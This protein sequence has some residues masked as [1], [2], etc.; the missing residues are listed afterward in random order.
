MLTLPRFSYVKPQ[1]IKEAISYYIRAKKAVYLAGGTDLIPRMQLRLNKPELVIDLK[2][3]EGIRGV[4]VN[5]DTILI[6]ALTTLWELQRVEILQEYF[7]HFIDAINT[8]SCNTIR[9]RATIG[10]NILQ[11]LRCLFYNQ[12]E[13]WRKAKGT[14]VKTGG[15]K[16]HVTGKESCNANYRSDLGP[17]LVSLQARVI[18]EGPTG[19]REILI[20]D[21]YTGKATHPYNLSQGEILTHVVLPQKK[22]KGVYWKLKV[23]GEIDYPEAS[24]AMSLV[25]RSINIVVGALGPSP[26]VLTLSSKDQKEAIDEF[27]EKIKPIA[28]TFLEPQYRWEMAK[29]ITKKLLLEF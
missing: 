29:Y 5:N 14:C 8:T 23:R 27:F 13:F 15:T 22:I 10:G 6:G 9:T 12:S 20:N 21:L 3:I 16:C 1:N 28:N 7:P 4:C 19:K 2:G 26:Y 17:V 25:D 24:V 11:E 18:L